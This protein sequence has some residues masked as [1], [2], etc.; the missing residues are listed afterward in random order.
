MLCERVDESPRVLYESAAFVQKNAYSV[1]LLP[2]CL[3]L[4]AC[5]VSP[6]ATA[7]FSRRNVYCGV[8]LMLS[9]VEGTV[10]DEVIVC[11]SETK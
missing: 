10:P 6:A 1:P 8:I 5:A 3:F 4:A 9:F 11:G 2:L 7:D